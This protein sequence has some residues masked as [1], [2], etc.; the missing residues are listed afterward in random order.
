NLEAMK[1]S[2]EAAAI[3]T[4]STSLI[5][6]ADMLMAS[7]GYVDPTGEISLVPNP[8]KQMALPEME[9]PE[10]EQPG[11]EQPG[12]EQPGLPGQEVMPPP[13]ND[14]MMSQGMQIPPSMPGEGMQLPPEP[15]P[16]Q[17]PEQMLEEFPP[18]GFNGVGVG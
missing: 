1:L 10:M 6:V 9:Q 16:S 11:M 3:A 7:A 12:M 2:F 5:K 18:Q 8:P 15:M 14:G 4:T 17:T 13:M